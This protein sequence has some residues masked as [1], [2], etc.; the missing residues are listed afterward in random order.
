[1]IQELRFPKEYRLED[2][3]FAHLSDELESVIVDVRSL[4]ASSETQSPSPQLLE[5]TLSELA[6]QLWRLGNRLVD[7]VTREPTEENRIAYGRLQAAWDLL[8]KL[9]I[10]VHDYSHQE[11]ADHGVTGL[12]ILAEEPRDDLKRPTV[13]ETV[14]PAVSYQGRLQW[15]A[16]VIVGVPVE[17]NDAG[18]AQGADKE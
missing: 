14:K 13:V 3:R 9:G 7:P 15:M 11:I 16:E 12:K 1:M 10:E 5:S 2:P 18:A 4:A 17:S 6:V 8:K